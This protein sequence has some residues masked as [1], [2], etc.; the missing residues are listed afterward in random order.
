MTPIE[1][2]YVAGRWV[3][4]VHGKRFRVSRLTREK[5]RGRQDSKEVFKTYEEAKAECARRN[6]LSE[7]EPVWWIGE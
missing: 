3:P 7:S 1:R 2:D 4:S 5:R 6:G